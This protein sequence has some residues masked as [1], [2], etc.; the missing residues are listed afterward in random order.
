MS[1]VRVYLEF[2]V[3][4]SRTVPVA[5]ITLQNCGFDFLPAPLSDHGGAY[6]PGHFPYRLGNEEPVKMNIP[7]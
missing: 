3:L 1:L 4:S 2:S 5:V 6:L 7:A